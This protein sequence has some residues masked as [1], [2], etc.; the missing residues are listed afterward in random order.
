MLLEIRTPDRVFFNGEV[1]SVK[2]PG[3]NGAFEILNRHAAIT[4]LLKDGKIEVKNSEKMN[5]FHIDTGL[6][7]MY[8][9]KVV[10]LVESVIQ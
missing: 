2:V 6:I 10:I 4:S 7:E 1:D 5:S 8:E 3:E 9:N